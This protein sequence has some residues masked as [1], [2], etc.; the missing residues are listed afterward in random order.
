MKSSGF[1]PAEATL[2]AGAPYYYRACGLTIESAIALPFLPCPRQPA[3]VIVKRG[4]EREGHPRARGGFE[5]SPNCIRFYSS[6]MGRFEVC[7]GRQIVVP[8]ERQGQIG[9]IAAIVLGSLMPHLCHQR[10]LLPLHACT[11][12]F[13]GKAIALAGPSG[14][15]KSTLLN[16]FLQSGHW[17]L[18]DDLCATDLSETAKGGYPIALPCGPWLKLGRDVPHFANEEAPSLSRAGRKSWIDF[19]SQFRAEPTP[20]A[21]VLLISDAPATEP[22]EFQRLKGVDALRAAGTVVSRWR[23]ALASQKKSVLVERAAAL[24]RAAPVYRLRRPR[25]LENLSD[26]VAAVER[27]AEH[28]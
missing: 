16:A 27:F 1:V 24:F 13:N 8:A 3:N 10:G 26:V 15:G 21:A 22:I 2:D 25:V 4:A 6:Q 5:G 7:E 17:F 11:L 19:T 14:M 12:S 28:I 9:L 18:S 23:Q 20:L